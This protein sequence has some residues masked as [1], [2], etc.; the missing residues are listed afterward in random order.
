MTTAPTTATTATTTAPTTLDTRATDAGLL[1]LRL[2]FGLLLAVHGT[3]KLFGWFGGF[4]WSATAQAFDGMGYNPGK[5][6][7]TLAG[8]S[9][10]GGGL[11]LAAGLLTPLGAAIALGTMLNAFTATWSGGFA[12]W[13]MSVLFAL[14][15]AA[16]AF[17]GPGRY[18]L[19]HNRPWQ[20]HGLTW[21]GA[22][23]ALAVI[24]GLITL[25]A[26]WAL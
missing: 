16:L 4:G 6:F 3:Q 22:A 1:V 17:T 2:G 15:A 7:G 8:L 11:L 14:P 19:D 10:I 20:R 5:F 21:A 23:I 12:Q 26:K 9:E 13:E 24:A 25:A 18:S